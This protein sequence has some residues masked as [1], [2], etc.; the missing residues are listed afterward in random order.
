MAF[1]KSIQLLGDIVTYE[2]SADVKKYTLRDLGFAE[3]KAGNFQL[4][5]SLDPNSPFNQG[6]KVKI[7]VDKTLSGFK[8][9][10]TTANGLKAVNIFK[11]ENKKAETEQFDYVIGQLVDR[12]VLKKI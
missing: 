10:T 7:V 5:R 2:L 6:I 9:S 1:E 11:D 3:T 12:D 4:E 8:M